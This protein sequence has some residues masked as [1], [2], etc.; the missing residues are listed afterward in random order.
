MLLRWGNSAIDSLMSLTEENEKYLNVVDAVRDLI[1]KEHTG[2]FGQDFEFAG[3]LLKQLK[4]PPLGPGCQ[5][6][7]V[8][9]RQASDGVFK[10]LDLWTM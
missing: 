5:T 8:T 10:V 7:V 1:F 9:Y 6:L 3:Q 2:R 4:I